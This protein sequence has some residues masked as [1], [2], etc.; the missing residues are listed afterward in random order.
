MRFVGRNTRTS[1]EI[2]SLIRKDIPEYPPDVL[3][4]AITNAV[5]HRDWFIE[6]ANVFVEIYPDRI[7]ISN[8]GGLPQILSLGDLGRRSVRRNPLIADLFHRINF[9]EKAGTG[10]QRMRNEMRAQGCPEPE[11]AA[12]GF[13]AV[14][15]RPN[16]MVRDAGATDRTAT[17]RPTDIDSRAVA[18]HRLLQEVS[19]EMTGQDL[20][21]ALGLKNNPHFRRAYLIPA[22]QAGLLEM[23][24]PNKPRSKNQ[25]YR[26]SRA[27]REFLVSQAA[28]ENATVG[29]AE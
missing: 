23:T 10:I 7:E 15:L 2:K 1:Y 18:M 27:G 4:E 20:R 28:Q 5:M 8:P 24:I 21:R 12:N 14:T 17:G 11:F 6:G 29:A 13:F 19:G 3:R 16:P 22:L 25:R 26:L 9:I